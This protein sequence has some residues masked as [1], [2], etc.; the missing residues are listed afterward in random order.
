MEKK[1]NK[2]IP[3][4]NMLLSKNPDT[5]LPNIWPAYFS[6]AEECYIWDIDNNKYLDFSYMGVGTN[7][8]GYANKEV[9]I[10]VKKAIEKGNI[11][12]LNSYEEVLL[13]EKAI[14]NA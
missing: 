13:A 1:A 6:K 3:N 11:S 2:I 5:I 7:I 12:T 10:A 14:K 9:D 8:L 4:G